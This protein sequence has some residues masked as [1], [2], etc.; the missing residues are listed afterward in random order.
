MLSEQ[1]AY[2][3]TLPRMNAGDSQATHVAPHYVGA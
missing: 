3:L 2:R 1:V